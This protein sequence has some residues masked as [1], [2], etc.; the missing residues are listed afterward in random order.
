MT[1]VNDTFVAFSTPDGRVPNDTFVALV[2]HLRLRNARVRYEGY[3]KPR[4][5]GYIKVRY[6]GYI[7]V[8]K[9]DGFYPVYSREGTKKYARRSPSTLF[10][11][12]KACQ[13]GFLFLTTLLYALSRLL[14]IFYFIFSFPTTLLYTFLDALQAISR[15]GVTFL[16]SIYLLYRTFY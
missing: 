9:V 3:I 5:K 13:L 15:L 7:K 6:K 4:Y 12:V 1:G 2:K 14:L 16:L 10:F 11:I 8:R